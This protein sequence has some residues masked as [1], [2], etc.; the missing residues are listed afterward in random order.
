MS[1]IHTRALASTLLGLSV[2]GV[3]CLLG[4]GL[5]AYS[6]ELAVEV[7]LTNAR[8]GWPETPPGLGVSEASDL[9]DP[10]GTPIQRRWW[11][12]KRSSGVA[13]RSRV[14]SCGPN[15]LDEGGEGDDVVREWRH[16]YLLV[17]ALERGPS[18]LRA[19]GALLLIQAGLSCLGWSL[20]W[21]ALLG[22][23]LGATWAAWFYSGLPAGVVKA[24]GGP[25]RTSL[26]LVAGG[27][28][29]C[30][31]GVCPGRPWVPAGRLGGCGRHAFGGGG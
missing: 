18:L 8:L 16:D 25:L 29:I 11:V 30:L 27:A 31:R 14:Y 22:V 20:R 17:S 23:A 28:L 13:V 7:S 26:T 21:S 19:L 6:P 2:L 3:S 10:W 15:R 9:A 4:P 24:L 12:S 1:A 5:R